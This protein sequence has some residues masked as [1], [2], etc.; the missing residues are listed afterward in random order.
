VHSYRGYAVYITE[1]DTQSWDLGD[2]YVILNPNWLWRALR[3]RYQG[4]WA[5]LENAQSN[6]PKRISC[7]AYLKELLQD[8]KRGF[9][10]IT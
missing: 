7:A 4:I 10:W 5:E 9:P 2:G 6:N 1:E 3:A 8:E